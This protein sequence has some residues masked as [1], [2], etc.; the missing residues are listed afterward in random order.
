M[1]HRT[2][3][4]LEIPQKFIATLTNPRRLQSEQFQHSI[5]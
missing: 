1:F 3:L 2:V 5:S 4:F